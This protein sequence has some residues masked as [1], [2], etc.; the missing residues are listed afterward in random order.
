MY[1]DDDEMARVM[2]DIKN[3]LNENGKFLNQKPAYNKILH[4][5]VSLQLGWI[6]QTR[7]VTK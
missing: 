2:P 6:M 1:E 7:K 4:S 3:S 5:E